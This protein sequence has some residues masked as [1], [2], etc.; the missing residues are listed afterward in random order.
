MSER[1]LILAAAQ[2][3]RR[4]P[5]EWS[6]FL[7]ELANYAEDIVVACVRSQ[8]DMLPVA[9]GRAQSIVKL[10]QT[11]VDCRKAADEIV[12]RVPPNAKRS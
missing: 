6:K 9:Q 5:D 8:L 10:Q 11:L 3:S 2:L 12:N 1:E 4:A 7:E